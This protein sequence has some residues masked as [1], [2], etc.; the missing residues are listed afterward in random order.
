MFKKKD[1]V[2]VKEKKK[3]G[4]LLPAVALAVG[5]V[6]FTGLVSLQNS[7][8]KQPDMSDVV[9]TRNA[10][11]GNAFIDKGQAGEWFK[12]IQVNSNAVADGA[13]TTLEELEKELPAY[14]NTDTAKNSMITDGIWDRM[15]EKEKDYQDR[16]ETGFRVDSIDKAVSGTVRAGD[17]ITI[18]MIDKDTGA[19]S[20]NFAHV[21]VSG[22]FNSDGT[23]IANDDKVSS[24]SV[25]NIWLDSPQ[26]AEFNKCLEKSSVR[27]SLDN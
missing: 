22:A 11:S 12:V 4:I 19:E 18:R 25:F 9:V 16:A 2:K 15:H 1:D 13:Y 3:S 17:Y 20:G 6:A 14:V 27:V 8:I 7:L 26:L 5:V 24:A 21:Y 23:A 10:I